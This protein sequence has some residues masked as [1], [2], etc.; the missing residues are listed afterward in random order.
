MKFGKDRMTL[1]AD[2]L[3]DL[4]QRVVR[5]GESWARLRSAFSVLLSQYGNAT[6]LAA[7]FIGGQYVCRDFK[8]GE[9]S[10]DPV[11]PVPGDKQREALTFLTENV[12]SDK[13]FQF[14]PALLRRLTTEYWSHWGSDSMF[15]SSGV[16]YPIYSRVLALQRMVLNQCFS[17]SILSRIQNQELQS[18]PKSKPLKMEEI[19]STLTESVW[20]ELNGGSTCYSTVRRNL[21]REHLRRLMTMVVGTRRS[22]LEDVYGYIVFLGNSGTVPADARSLAR[23]HLTDLSGRISKVLE[24]R[25]GTLDDPTRAHLIECKQ[26]IAKTLDSSYT[27][28]EL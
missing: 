19:F 6:Y 10:H 17:P 14:S 26:R 7:G 24:T 9:K 3:K 22:S 23:M 12:L 1:A 20:S 2:L 15:L 21:Q 25:S 4:D 18:D 16:D 5:D 8:G 11:M 13:A 28:S 27:S